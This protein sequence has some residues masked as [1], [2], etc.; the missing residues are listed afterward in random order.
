M[1]SNSDA[2][3]IQPVAS[4]YPGSKEYTTQTYFWEEPIPRRKKTQG[5]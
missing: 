3:V 5:P 2:S 4:R 1:D